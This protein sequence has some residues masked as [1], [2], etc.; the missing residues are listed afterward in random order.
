MSKKNPWT[1]LL[2]YIFTLIQMYIDSPI[3]AGNLN[4]LFFQKI[5]SVYLSEGYKIR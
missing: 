1:F 5:V 3:I 2:I 4:S